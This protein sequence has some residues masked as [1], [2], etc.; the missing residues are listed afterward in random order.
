MS[1]LIENTELRNRVGIFADRTDAGLQ[2]A[3][4]LRSY[5]GSN[6]LVLAIPSGG[7]PVGLEITE[8]LGLD[9]DLILVRKVQ[10]PWNT[11]AGFGAVNMDSDL[12]MNEPL[13]NMLNLTREQIEQQVEK[14]VA[15]L[16]KRNDLFRQN[17][18][19]PELNNR[20]IIVV[21]DGLASGYTMRAALAFV[22]KRNPASLTIAVPTGSADTVRELLNEVNTL[23]CLNIRESYPY[24][25]ATAYRDWYDLTDDDVMNLIAR[26]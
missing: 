20:H 21:D 23:C 25:V 26:S 14:T 5:T 11:E 7:V 18:A 24:A 15:T 3:E 16:E 9:L 19:F 1:L 2:L 13:L 10:I 17:R 8:S 12:L 6:A 22:K 4:E